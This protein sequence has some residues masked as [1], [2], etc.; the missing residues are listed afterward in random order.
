MAILRS[1]RSKSGG[2]KYLSKR[3]PK[4]QTDDDEYEE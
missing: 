1:S 2:I 4:M 3:L